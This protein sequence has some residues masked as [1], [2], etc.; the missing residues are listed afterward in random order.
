VYRG[1]QAEVIVVDVE[2]E[3]AV[4]PAT[5]LIAAAPSRAK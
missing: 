3:G 5:A 4:A 2:V 1:A